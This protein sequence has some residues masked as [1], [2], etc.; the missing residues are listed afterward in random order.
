MTGVP[1]GAPDV[2]PGSIAS[3]RSCAAH[4]R[5]SPIYGYR[6]TAP[7]GPVCAK[8]DITGRL[9]GVHF[10][11]A[12]DIAGLVQGDWNDPRVTP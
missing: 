9:S 4:F 11:S 12:T 5:P 1:L 6:E 8:A 3:L 10:G 7:T 2:C